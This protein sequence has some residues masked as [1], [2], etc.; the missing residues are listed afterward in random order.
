M[1]WKKKKRYAFK[2]FCTANDRAAENY[3]LIL[4]ALESVGCA[5]KYIL[6]NHRIKR[7]MWAIIGTALQQA[8]H[9]WESR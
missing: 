4:W 6:I 7:S 1:Y 3:W 9:T 8:Q 5:A 2:R